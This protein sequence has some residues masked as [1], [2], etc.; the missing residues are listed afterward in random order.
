M[1][2]KSK[3]KKKKKKSKTKEEE[4]DEV[5]CTNCKATNHKFEDCFVKGGPKYKAQKKG[6]EEKSDQKANIAK[7]PKETVISY[8][9]DEDEAGE[10]GEW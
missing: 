1:S 7:A 4:S 6:K 5:K 8:E 10:E 9:S 3:L 2:A